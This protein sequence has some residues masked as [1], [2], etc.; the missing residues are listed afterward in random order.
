[1]L[2]MTEIESEVISDIDMYLL[3]E[4]WLRGGISYIAKRFSKAN[5]KYMQSYGDKIQSKY[6]KYLDADDLYDWA[7][8]QY[9]PFMKVVK[10]NWN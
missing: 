1:M 10:T 2:K 8:S 5:N 9:L 3:V 6:I 4:K 7:M